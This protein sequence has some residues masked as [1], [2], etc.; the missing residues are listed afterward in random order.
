MLSPGS[1][2]KPDIVK[3]ARKSLSD[4]SSKSQPPPKDSAENLESEDVPQPDTGDQSIAQGEPETIV[5]LLK[6]SKADDSMPEDVRGGTNDVVKSVELILKGFRDEFRSNMDEFRS[7]MNEVRSE[8]DSVKSKLSSHEDAISN[9]D[10]PAMRT[11]SNL[12]NSSTITTQLRPPSSEIS[13]TAQV[14]ADQNFVDFKTLNQLDQDIK[15]WRDTF[16]NLFH[17]FPILEKIMKGKIEIPDIKVSQQLRETFGL[18][19]SYDDEAFQD[20]LYVLKGKMNTT[21]SAVSGRT[22]S[23]VPEKTLSSVILAIYEQNRSYYFDCVTSYFDRRFRFN[24]WDAPIVEDLDTPFQL[25]FRTLDYENH[26]EYLSHISVH[27]T[28]FIEL[29]W[30]I[31][32]EFEHYT[33]GEEFRKLGHV[34]VNFRTTD[35]YRQ[36]K[37]K[38]KNYEVF[39]DLFSK[40]FDLLRKDN[41]K[42]N[43]PNGSNNNSKKFTSQQN[44][45]NKNVL[46]KNQNLNNSSNNQS[47]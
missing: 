19:R 16:D 7:N 24:H 13:K 8:I 9:A 37:N 18:D 46:N 22:Y 23:V 31:A 20:Y 11:N 47:Q 25:F 39:L 41:E 5:S 34:M 42:R 28:A 29:K 36:I 38:S 14:W 27:E 12:T 44:S 3:G 32:K 17:R 21:L 2:R 1:S 30:L 6:Q 35:T 15:K 40:K 45:S 10:S 4:A 43:G 26:F 33:K